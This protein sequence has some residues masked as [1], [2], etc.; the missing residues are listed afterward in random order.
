MSDHALLVMNVSNA[1]SP[2]AVW[3]FNLPASVI[4]NYRNNPGHYPSYVDDFPAGSHRRALVGG[5]GD[6]VRHLGRPDHPALHLQHRV[7]ADV[8][9]AARSVR[10]GDQA[11]QGT[12]LCPIPATCGSSA[13]P[14]SPEPMGSRMSTSGQ[15]ARSSAVN[16]LA[17]AS[18]RN[19]PPIAHTT[20][21]A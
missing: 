2:T 11:A 15:R 12:G 5:Q 8:R 14:S 1:T 16:R 17:I 9:V 10:V 20:G 13:A 3:D 7:R 4:D 6:L 19:T 18:A 21:E